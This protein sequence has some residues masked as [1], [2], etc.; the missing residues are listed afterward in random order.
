MTIPAR[1]EIL[2]L[3]AGVAFLLAVLPQPARSYV[4][5]GEHILDLTVKALGKAETLEATQTVTISAP[6][7]APAG[8]LQETVR[9]R[10]PFDL[11]ADAQGNAYERHLLITGPNALLV[12]NGIAQDGPLPRYL[13]YHDILMI[14]SRPALVDQLRTLGVDVQVSSLGRMED[15]YCYVV[16]ARFPNDD[17]AQ[18]WV[19]KD[20]FL[21][22]RLLLPPSALQP[23]TGSV[24]I[25]YG[26]WTLVDGAAYPLHVVLMQDH[27]VM[28]EVRVD[29]VRVNPAFGSEVFDRAALQWQ[30]SRPSLQED[31]AQNPPPATV[32]PQLTE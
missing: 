17:A 25:R 23:E 2:K 12:V 30:W 1:R 16:G 27:Q 20:S 4:L 15:H 5:M 6:S 14:K 19:D 18:L 7:P 9:I 10:K 22:F 26:N 28:E 21:P 29:R 13:R 3:V 31:S 32:L 24:E 8:S 11:R